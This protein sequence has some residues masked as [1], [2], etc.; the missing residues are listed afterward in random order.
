MPMSIDE[1]LTEAQVLSNDAKAILAEKLIAN[2][3]QGIDPQ[4]TK[5]HLAEVKRRRD[6]IH[7]GIVQPLDGEECLTKV[8][9]IIGQ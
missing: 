1:I 5:I 7:T 3:E 2:I 4:I 6:E 8:R 9:E